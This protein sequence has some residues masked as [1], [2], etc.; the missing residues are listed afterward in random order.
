MGVTASNGS[1]LRALGL[2][3]SSPPESSIQK[4]ENLQWLQ[5]IETP[6]AISSLG[7]GLPYGGDLLPGELMLFDVKPAT[8]DFLGLGM[9]GGGAGGGGGGGG[10][11]EL[12]SSIGGAGGLDDV[13][14]S[15]GGDS[16]GRTH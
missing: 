13:A 1:L 11:S 16:R 14:G 4:Q 10:F 7:L 15:F 12:M 5:Q 9:G 3:S 6:N 2:S 8:V